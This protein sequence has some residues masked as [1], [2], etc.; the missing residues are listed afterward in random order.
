MTPPR[1]PFT[2]AEDEKIRDLWAEGFSDRK[3]GRAIG[4]APLSVASRRRLLGYINLNGGEGSSLALKHCTP[5]RPRG[6]TEAQL[7]WALANNGEEPEAGLMLLYDR[8]R[9][10]FHSAGQ[11]AT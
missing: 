4:R 9:T 6:Y 8:E 7:A 2:E 11:A 1:H 5:D 10:R 3:I